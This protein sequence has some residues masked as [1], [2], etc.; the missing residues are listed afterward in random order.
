ML[1]DVV[2]VK[3]VELHLTAK[4]SGSS[5][6]Y[7]SYASSSSAVVLVVVVVVIVVVVVVAKQR[8]V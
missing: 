7:A 3:Y 1:L 6:S 2:L 4:R 8:G 5:K